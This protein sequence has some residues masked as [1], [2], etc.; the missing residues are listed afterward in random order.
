MPKLSDG[1]TYTCPQT[2]QQK[3]AK[4][5]QGPGLQWVPALVR[6]SCAGARGSPVWVSVSSSVKPC[7]AALV[8]GAAGTEENFQRRRQ[9]L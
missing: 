3:E 6:A 9:P 5:G 4:R 8:G 7:R 2:S 1:A